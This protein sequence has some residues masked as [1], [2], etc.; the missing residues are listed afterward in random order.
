[1]KRVDLLRHLREQG[2]EVL[3]EGG[4]HTVA[5]NPANHKT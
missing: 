2:C 5:F 1:M 4:R 3:R